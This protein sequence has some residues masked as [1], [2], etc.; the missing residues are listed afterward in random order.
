VWGARVAPQAAGTAAAKPARTAEQA[1]R[2][3]LSQVA[4]LYRLNAD[5]V[6][7][8]V[9]HDLHDTGRGGIIAR[10]R[11]SVNG[12]EVFREETNVL[13]DRSLGLVS[14]S[15]S[16]PSKALVPPAAGAVFTLPADRAVAIAL[17]DFS[18]LSSEPAGAARIGDADGG[19]VRFSAPTELSN[20]P[21][22]LAVVHPV[23]A[24]A[25]YYREADALVPAYYV[26]VMGEVDAYSYVIAAD[27]GSVL[28]RH[29]L[30]ENDAA[31]YR[32][33]ASASA[34]NLPDDGP[35]GTVGTPHPTGV[36]DGYAPPMTPPSL[37]TLQNGPISTNDPWLPP[38]ATQ[39][40]GNNVDA[41]ADLAAPDGFS[42]G[43]LRATT[44]G[45]GT[46]DRVY[47]TSQPPAASANQQMAAI[48][49][50]FFDTNYLHD[51]FYDAGYN[52]AAGNMQTDNLGRGGVAGDPLH[53]E[54]Q[55][56]SGLN[57]ANMSTPA[58][59]ASGRMQM[60]VFVN[61]ATSSFLKVQAPAAISGNYAF[62]TAQFGPQI[63]DLSGQVVQALDAVAPAGDGCTAFTNP[64]AIAG[65]IALIDRGSCTFVTKVQNAMDAGAIG[66]IIVDN[67]VGAASP[68]GMAGTL[69]TSPDYS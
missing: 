28:F 41:Y 38:G 46:F 61:S 39:T 29:C 8:A 24:K 57:N 10:F 60:Y 27:D 65:H 51:W 66:V 31:S 42:A 16:I 36:P 67:V 33:W 50:L 63:F 58:D 40:T 26:E 9:L 59:G 45:P 43:D 62:G 4:S 22:D 11:Q 52:E 23:R 1:A 20:L 54:A 53:A 21:K 2:T 15:G 47:D 14:V 35:Q 7:G 49:Q 25:V 19:Y 12:I 48:T 3:H 44:T 13:M 55:D 17:Q 69:A 32:V 5:D 37:L 68:P 30:T 18:E 64:G 34:G 56:Y 6:T